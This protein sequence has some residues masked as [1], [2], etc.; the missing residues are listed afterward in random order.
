MPHFLFVVA[1]T[2]EPG[3]VGN[4]E[5]LARRAAAGLP[6]DATQTWLHLAHLPM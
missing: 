3:H 5:W 6:A 4:T 2:R 1:S